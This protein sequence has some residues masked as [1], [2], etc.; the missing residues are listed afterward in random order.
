M[1]TYDSF[2]VEVRMTPF[3]WR[4]TGSAGTIELFLRKNKWTLSSLSRCCK[5]RANSRSLACQ[6]CGT[7]DAHSFIPMGQS[8]YSKSGPQKALATIGENLLPALAI[9]A[10]HLT[11]NP[12]EVELNASRAWALVENLYLQTWEWESRLTALEMEEHEVKTM[13]YGDL[14]RLADKFWRDMVGELT[15]R[16]IALNS[17]V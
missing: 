12:L 2:T 6:K 10:H 3:L 16:E 13:T 4:L 1:K 8:Y 11:S 15:Q 5:V 17:I 7:L 9:A 14:D